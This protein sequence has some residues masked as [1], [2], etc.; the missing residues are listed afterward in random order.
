[1]DGVNGNS[2]SNGC[3]GQLQQQRLEV[4]MTGHNWQ[5]R[6]TSLEAHQWHQR[7]WW[8]PQ[9]EAGRIPDAVMMV[10]VGGVARSRVGSGGCGVMG[11]RAGG[12]LLVGL[13]STSGMYPTTSRD[14]SQ[15][16]K[17]ND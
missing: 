13:A 7:Q 4:A 15:A 17:N 14:V 2:N 6:S 1:V 12:R 5:R 8:W 16:E 11:T 10:C 3:G 9:K